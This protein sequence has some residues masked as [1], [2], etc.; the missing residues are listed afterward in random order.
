MVRGLRCDLHP[1][2]WLSQL[3]ERLAEQLEELELIGVNHPHVTFLALDKLRRLRRLSLEFAAS[4]SPSITFRPPPADHCGL[5][6]LRVSLVDLESMNN[7]LSL[8][9]AHAPTLQVRVGHTGVANAYVSINTPCSTC[10]H[11]ITY[12]NLSALSSDKGILFLAMTVPRT[13]ALSIGRTLPPAPT[14]TPRFL[15]V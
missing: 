8:V 1:Y 10:L 2:F 15:R 13:E 3:L 11:Q 9:T 4:Y 5:Q 14:V 12:G 7:L 6:W